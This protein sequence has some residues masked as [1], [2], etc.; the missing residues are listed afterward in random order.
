M[1]KKDIYTYTLLLFITILTAFFAS[2]FTDIKI[3]GIIILLLSALKFILVAFNFMELKKAHS[4]WKM[5]LL[6]YLFLF[7]IIISTML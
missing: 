4:F 6:G 5:L 3:I 1:N 7:V 2:S